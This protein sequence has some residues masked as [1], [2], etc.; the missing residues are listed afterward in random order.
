MAQ[1][2]FAAA[3]IDIV[4]VV[5][6]ATTLGAVVTG[7]LLALWQRGKDALRRDLFSAVPTPRQVVSAAGK[8]VEANAAFRELFGKTHKPMPQLLSEEIGE[9]EEALELIERLNANAR[10]GIAGW[11][12][13]RVAARS[14]SPSGAGDDRPRNGEAPGGWRYVAAYPLH[15][16]PGWTYWEVDDISPRRGASQSSGQEQESLAALFE[17]APIGFYSTDQDGNFL[18]LN[19]T[20][21]A[22]LG[23]TKK[24]IRAEGIRLHDVIADGPPDN[25]EA[26]CPFAEPE[27]SY[28]KVTLRDAEGGTFETSI[29]Q[30]LVQGAEGG[31]LRTR[32]FVRDLSRERAMTDALEYYEHRFERFF[33]EAPVGIALIDP[34]GVIIEC[35]G[36]FHRLVDMEAES[37]R[38]K[39]FLDL[40]FEEDRA[41]VEP[42]LSQ[43]KNGAAPQNAKSPIEVRL[44][45]KGET[46]CSMYVTHPENDGGA[47]SGCIAHFIDATEQKNLEVQVVQ[48]QKM[49]AVGQL[50]GGIAHDFNNLLTAMIGFCDLLLLRHRPGDQSFADIM[51][52]QQNANRA[53]NLVRQLL[54]FSRQQTLQPR[55]L[56][57]TDILAELSHLL[58]RLIGG[59]IELKMTHG[60][61]LGMVKADQGQ[62]EQVIINLAVNARD[63]MSEDGT[64]VL[65]IR[66]ANETVAQARQFRGEMMPR[67]DYV[68]I[69]VSDTGSGI[70]PEH[71]DRIFDPFFST[72]DVGQGTGLGLSTVYG[73]V[74]QSGGYIFVDSKPGEGSV[75][76]IYLPHTTGGEVQI[77][78]GAET[79]ASRDLTGVGTLLLVED[80]DAV[81]AFGARALVNKGYKV[82]EASSGESALDVLRNERDPIDLLI[83]DVAMPQMDG[84]TLVKQ[85][86]GQRPDLKV[87]FI[88]GYAE[89]L[90]R[91]RVDEDERI[92]FLQKPFSLKQLASKVKEVL[93][94]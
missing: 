91:R 1:W 87:I 19:R 90:F 78:S 34:A 62:L 10:R 89:D 57:V 77:E 60:R 94:Q 61:D 13:V 84:P 71:L 67:G 16:R 36:E 40:V 29:A 75:F 88:S 76:S 7:T 72:K 68:L 3:E 59:A 42:A 23:L 83:T 44:G 2:D 47:P 43:R 45:P 33:Q 48:S 22:W 86:R 37:L 53:A 31:A 82:L 39:R 24:K 4:I 11:A 79:K 73:I 46:V 92:H 30:D 32:S 64:G 69:E 74:K 52:I 14:P 12:K 81:R 17:D 63:A 56:N 25:V 80:E 28:G 21:E 9:D 49:Q 18:F 26:Y 38:K 54:A 70:A 51:Q 27:L 20:L 66:T 41:A 8:S 65:S 35:N 5:L 55:R 58:R 93:A 15:D 85:V 6:I 50:A